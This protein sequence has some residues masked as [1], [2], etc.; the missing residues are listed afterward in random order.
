MRVN[1]NVEFT[2]EELR[3]YAAD[4][5]RRVIATTLN[6][7]VSAINKLKLGPQ[8]S[9][10]LASALGAV[11]GAIMEKSDKAS[12]KTS[13]APDIGPFAFAGPGNECTRVESAPDNLGLD[14]GW[15]CCRC[16][17]YNGIQRSTCRNCK[18][19]RC[20]VRV[21]P[22]PAEP[23]VDAGTPVGNA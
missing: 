10:V 1:F 16:S 7:T 20:D 14:E 5:A 6:D 23:D 9:Q 3:K 21:P 22:P 19:A 11:A 12:S 8:H 4:T 13:R 15:A 17:V 2:D 18:H